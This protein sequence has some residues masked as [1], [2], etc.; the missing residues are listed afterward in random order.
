M[1]GFAGKM[2]HVDLTGGRLHDRTARR[3]I[4]SQVH[5]RQRDGDVLPAE[6]HA[7]RRRSAGTGKYAVVLHQRADRRAHL[8]AKPRDRHGQVAR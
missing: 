2:L 5:G 7:P 6:A 3:S 4:L 1:Y 8:R